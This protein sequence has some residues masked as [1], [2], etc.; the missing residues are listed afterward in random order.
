MCLCVW[1]ACLAVCLVLF[2]LFVYSFDFVVF[3]VL[4]SPVMRLLS[5]CL[6]ACMRALLLVRDVCL[7][8]FDLL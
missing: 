3:V 5:V 2:F 1:D 8:G 7:F 6:L 4:F